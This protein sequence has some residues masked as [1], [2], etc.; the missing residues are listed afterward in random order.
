MVSSALMTLALITLSFGLTFATPGKALDAETLLKN[1]QEA[2]RLNVAFTSMKETDPCTS[3]EKAC[4][5]GAVAACR[6]GTWAVAK[7]QCSKTQACFALPSV[8]QLG[9]DVTCTTED[10]V[11]SL[12]NATGAAG[13]IFGVMK[14]NAEDSI[15]SPNS[16]SMTTLATASASVTPP[17]HKATVTIT[18][19]DTPVTFDPV[20]RTLS[21]EQALR[22][23]LGLMKHGATI[24][25]TPSVT[26][27]ITMAISHS[28]SNTAPTT[29][30]AG[31]SVSTTSSTLSSY[32]STP[33]TIIPSATI[34]VEPVITQSASGGDYS[35]GY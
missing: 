18:L 3:N 28:N 27:S 16:S 29:Y 19:S 4:M 17:P 15:P 13:G 11:I 7:G 21:P 26:P 5:S 14:T 22:V 9:I 25:E 34:D 2:Q 35:Y 1:G 8:Q 33:M 32:T 24:I 10:K 6:N 20:T 12:I 30:T 23:I 31:P